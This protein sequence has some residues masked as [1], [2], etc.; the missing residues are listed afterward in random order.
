MRTTNIKY[1][2][3]NIVSM[4]KYA[5]DNF[6]D[7]EKSEAEQWVL[8]RVRTKCYNCGNEAVGKVNKD[9]FGV[10]MTLY[11]PYCGKQVVSQTQIRPVPNYPNKFRFVFGSY[12]E[13][14]MFEI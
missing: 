14:P 13:N 8:T 6:F 3:A 2:G 4:T 1:D 11:C 12:I 5:E 7:F 9:S 10:F